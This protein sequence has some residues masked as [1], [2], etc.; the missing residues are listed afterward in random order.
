MREKK[1]KNKNAKKKKPNKESSW[2]TNFSTTRSLPNKMN[3]VYKYIIDNYYCVVG[4]YIVHRWQQWSKP[5]ARAVC[6]VRDLEMEIMHLGGFSDRY[7]V[8]SFL[9][10]EG[11]NY[12]L[13]VFTYYMLNNRPLPR[14]N[15]SKSIRLYYIIRGGH[16]RNHIILYQRENIIIIIIPTNA[17]QMFS[18]RLHTPLFWWF[19]ILVTTVQLHLERILYYYFV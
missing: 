5:C 7:C 18:V 16:L 8:F 11:I 12:T 3:L 17:V 6:G 4:T 13:R 15:K 1:T 14:W 19:D 10:S 9:I 2:R